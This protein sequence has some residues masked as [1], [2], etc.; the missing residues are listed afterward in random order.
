MKKEIVKTGICPKCK[1]PVIHGPLLR[2]NNEF[3]DLVDVISQVDYCP[4]CDDE[5]EV[6]FAPV[7][8]I[9]RN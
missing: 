5:Y 6:V 1:S 2:L 4:E 7:E 9:S 8:V 3:E